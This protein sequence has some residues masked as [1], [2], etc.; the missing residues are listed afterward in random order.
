MSSNEAR[1]GGLR[2]ALTATGH[3]QTA[4]EQDGYGRM[5][6][7]LVE[8]LQ[9]QVNDVLE[10]EN[11]GKVSLQ[12]VQRYLEKVMPPT[13]NPSVEGGYA[14][15]DCVLAQYPERAAVLRSKHIPTVNERPNT[16]IP[17]THRKFFQRR[18]DEF[19][20]IEHVLFPIA[21]NNPTF[22][23]PTIIGL[24]GMG[25][26]GKTHLAVE[27]AYRYK[28]RF[29]SGVFW[30][31]AIGTT[32]PEW[33]TQFAALAASA[34]YLPIDDDVSHPENEARRARHL[35]RYLAK[36]ADALLVLDNVENTELLLT[37]LP[38][39]AGG[40]IRC[41]ILYTSRNTNI[42]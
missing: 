23:S 26:I 35:C 40:E 42:A 28:E 34:E 36:H 22:P 11:Q 3:D 15:K 31:P 37:A 29:P 14:G 12:R 9:G 13:Q 2:L 33:Q 21:A 18:T 17:L 41:T 25:G 32:L 4:G 8:A 10:L 5:T 38:A 20:A 39:L 16:Y 24:V 6:K 7:Y 19:E 30:M 27:I 1:K